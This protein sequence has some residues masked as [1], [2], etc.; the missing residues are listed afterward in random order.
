MRLW[1]KGLTVNQQMHNLTV[2]D[3]PFFDKYLLPYDCIGTIAHAKVLLNAKLLTPDEEKQLTSTLIQ[4]YKEACEFKIPI[5]SELEDCHTTLESA[6]VEKLGD[7]GKKI[8][9]GRSRNDQ[10]ILTIR[11][12]LRELIKNNLHSLAALRTAVLEKYSLQKNIF[13]PGY[14]HLQPAMPSSVG[15]WWHWLA[16]CIQE[17]ISD[18][19]YLYNIIN[20]NPL[21]AAAGFGSGLPLDRQISTDYLGFN[22]VQRS[23]IDIQ[24]SRGRYEEKYLQWLSSIGSMAQKFC[25]DLSLFTTKEFG[26]VT[27]PQQFTT[28]SSIMPQKRNPDIVELTRARASSLNGFVCQI[29][30]ITGKL[31][32][33]YHRDLQLSKAPLFEGARQGQYVLQSL[34]LIVPVVEFNNAVLESRKDLELYATYEA[35]RL[36]KEGVPFREA[37]QK[38]A[39]DVSN[40]SFCSGNTQDQYNQVLLDV[41]NSVSKLR[42]EIELIN[43][44]VTNL[45]G[46]NYANFGAEP[47]CQLTR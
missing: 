3:D 2:G 22:T 25:W 11:L 10:V 46:I 30:W 44:A 36:V 33:N 42:D 38:V 21:G 13:L 34:N 7:V 1:E 12:F 27:L 31:P 9:T 29:Q 32:S 47:S 41:D 37:Y 5:T 4:I 28:G 35:Y 16:E 23:F 8:H 6:L 40:N 26:F 17:L 43:S 14:T 18:G 39:T 24:N 20:K 15:M 19:I 45:K